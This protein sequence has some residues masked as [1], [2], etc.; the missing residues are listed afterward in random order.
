MS[1]RQHLPCIDAS[2]IALGDGRSTVDLCRFED[3]QRMATFRRH[4]LETIL[5]VRG[6]L[7]EGIDGDHGSIFA[8][9]RPRAGRLS[10][11]FLSDGLGALFELTR[12]GRA[13]GASLNTIAEKMLALEPEREQSYRV[14][15]EAYGRNAMFEEAYADIP[16]PLRHARS[17]TRRAAVS[18]NR[19][20]RS[21]RL[22]L[23]QSVSIRFCVR[24]SRKRA[25][26]RR[27]SCAVMAFIGRPQPGLLKFFI[28][29]IANEL[30]RH[31]KLRRACPAQFVEDRP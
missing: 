29:D 19:G 24:A 23:A 27:L 31:Q 22:C 11:T 4:Y 26:A 30:G 7:L 5:L 9:A 16:C 18:G 2:S 3:A 1:G 13:S 25:A 15:V 20:G 10:R 12:Y 17:R 8:L 14:L 6:E 21:P 28:E